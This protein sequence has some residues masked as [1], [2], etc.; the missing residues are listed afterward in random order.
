MGDWTRKNLSEVEDSAGGHG[1]G[2]LLEGRFANAALE[3]TITGLSHQAIKPGKRL[4]FGHVHSVQEELY[5]VLSG[6]GTMKVG[7]DL[8][9][10]EKRLDAV[11][12]APGAWRGVEAG[13]DGLELLAFGAPR[14]EESDAD[15]DPGWWPQE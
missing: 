8:V 15:M 13:P 9:P 6:S 7:D 14:G 5:V 1:M 10:L 12:V 2:E 11:R 3:L 4:P